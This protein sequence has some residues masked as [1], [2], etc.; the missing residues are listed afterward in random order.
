[1]DT[2]EQKDLLEIRQFMYSFLSAVFLYPPQ[3]EQVTM[4]LQR[5]LFKEFPLD[6]AD[7]QY[8]E[9]LDNLV[10]WT[11]ENCASDLVNV[12]SSLNKDYAALFIGPSHLAA[13]PWESVYRTE[14]K[15]TFGEPTLEV[16]EWYQRC[17]LEFVHK[18]SEPD[19]HFG[20]ELEFMS[21]LIAHEL[22]AREEDDV[23]KADGLACEQLAFLGEHLLRWAKEFT[24][25]V[26]ASAQTLYYQGLAQLAYS[27]LI[28]DGK[29]LRDG[30][31]T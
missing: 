16:R 10:R 27:Y 6:I 26:Q 31:N 2:T 18:N 24:Q 15:L 21:K 28:W 5:Q 19:D 12:T 25:D 7:E 20:L 13:P 9:A 22:R 11:N 8:Q 23:L 14:E 4:I 30:K 17:G 29:Q 1:M 3:A